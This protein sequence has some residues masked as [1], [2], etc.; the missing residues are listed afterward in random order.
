MSNDILKSLFGIDMDEIRKEKGL[1]ASMHADLGEEPEV[2]RV[3]TVSASFANGDRSWT[4]DFWEVLAFSGP[5][6]LVKIHDTVFGELVRL[7]PKGERAWY[8][9]DEAFE[10][11]KKAKGNA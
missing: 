8:P 5:N 9:A 6:V 2:G 4:D 11:Y 7:F 1:A 3:Y 10:V